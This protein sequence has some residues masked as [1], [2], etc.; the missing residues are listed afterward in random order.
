LEGNIND[1]VIDPAVNLGD[2]VVSGGQREAVLHVIENEVELAVQQ[3]NGMGRLS[4]ET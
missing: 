3:D 4:R 2:V 1:D